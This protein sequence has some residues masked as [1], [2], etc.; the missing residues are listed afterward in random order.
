MS[1]FFNTISANQAFS[2]DT[3][4]VGSNLYELD[5]EAEASVAAAVAGTA[6]TAAPEVQNATPAPVVKEDPLPSKETPKSRVPSIKFLGRD[7][8]AQLLSSANAAV[9]YVPPNFGRPKFSDD[10]MEALITG[11]ASIAPDV[12]QHSRGAMFG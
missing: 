6:E 11:G 5:T 4:E 10:E 3:V 7:G 12:K 2:D 8:W 1:S 9:V